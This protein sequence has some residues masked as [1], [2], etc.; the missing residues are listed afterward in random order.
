MPITHTPPSNESEVVPNSNLCAICSQVIT[1]TNPCYIV[2]CKH[3]FHKLC[4]EGWLV[5]NPFCITCK[6]PIAPDEPKL[7]VGNCSP[8]R[9]EPAPR[10]APVPYRVITRN[11]AKTLNRVQQQNPVVEPEPEPAVRNISV[12]IIC[13]RC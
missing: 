1:N 12:S 9:R 7:V 5:E 13:S 2:V 3:I 8:Q 10:V 11:L 4:L 6:A